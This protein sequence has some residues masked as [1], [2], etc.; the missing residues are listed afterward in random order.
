MTLPH[1]SYKVR[2]LRHSF[3]V[4]DKRDGGEHEALQFKTAVEFVPGLAWNAYLERGISGIYSE[5]DKWLVRTVKRCV[6]EGETI[7]FASI[8]NLGVTVYVARK[9]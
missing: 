6:K 9:N 7:L 5:H 3:P 1:S 8:H 4:Y 2:G